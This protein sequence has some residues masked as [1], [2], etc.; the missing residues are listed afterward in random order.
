MPGDLL[1][2]P[3]EGSNSY[4]M[5]SAG[6]AGFAFP[7][8]DIHSEVI[9]VDGAAERLFAGISF[10]V[11]AQGA[12]LYLVFALQHTITVLFREPGAHVLYVLHRSGN[13]DRAI[14]IKTDVSICFVVNRSGIDPAV[15][16]GTLY[17][18]ERA[19][20]DNGNKPG[21]RSGHNSIK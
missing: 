5:V 8:G 21:K 6:S 7:I 19:E 3:V 15:F 10:H 13:E 16:Y 9:T 20:Q 12:S 2:F 14:L 1:D 4:E 18:G 17:T 11:K